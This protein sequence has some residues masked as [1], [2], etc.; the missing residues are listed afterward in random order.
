[1]RVAAG[2]LIALLLAGAVAGFFAWRRHTEP[3]RAWTEFLELEGVDIRPL[4]GPRRDRAEGLFLRFIGRD[5]ATPFGE[6]HWM[7]LPGVPEEKEDVRLAVRTEDLGNG[8]DGRTQLLELT[9]ISR[10]GVRH[11]TDYVVESLPESWSARRI[12]RREL[13]G[14]AVE[15]SAGSPEASVRLFFA[16]HDGRPALIRVEDG[17]GKLR[18]RVYPRAGAQHRDERFPAPSSVRWNEMLS[19]SRPAAI[20]EA[21]LWLGLRYSTVRPEGVAEVLERSDIL[22]RVQA[23]RTSPNPWIREA[24]ELAL[25]P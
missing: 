1:M 18:G 17:A 14:E 10:S 3:A 11:E 9:L 7:L 13:E 23:L 5:R 25:R 19:D 16:S 6:E 4:T 22:R 12:Q 8:P 24:V 20:L 21:L 15:L 2:V